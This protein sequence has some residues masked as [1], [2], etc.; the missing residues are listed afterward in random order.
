[1]LGFFQVLKDF[2][3]TNHTLK[4]KGLKIFEQQYM[5]LW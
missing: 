1:M 2:G 5:D 3:L 4:H